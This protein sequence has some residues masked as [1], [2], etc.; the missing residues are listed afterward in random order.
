MFSFTAGN[1]LHQ[2]IKLR[3][4]RSVGHVAY[5]EEMVNSYKISGGIRDR[6]SPH[7]RLGDCNAT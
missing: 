7:G 6:K 2:V 4:M 3:R 1:F 5:T